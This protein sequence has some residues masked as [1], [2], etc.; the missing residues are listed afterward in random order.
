MSD[1]C[2]IAVL[3]SGPAALAVGAAC[4]RRGA[5][6]TLVAPDPFE[7]WRPNYCLWRDELPDSLAS[8]IECAWPEVAVA[9]RY[10]EQTLKRGY[11]KIDNE[12]LRH[13]FWKHLDAGDTRV[14]AEPAVRLEPRDPGTWVH[15]ARDSVVRARV[16]IDASGA[17]SPFVRRVHTRAPA[18]QVAYGLLLDAPG[19][20]FPVH[21]ATLMDF[22]PAAANLGE[23]PSFVY[24]LPLS[25]D[26]VFLEET[27]LARR[28]SVS[29]A[30]LQ[31][32]L[33]ARLE[34]LGLQG[35]EHLGEE[36]CSIPMGLGLPIHGQSLVPFGAAAAM[37]HPASGY[38]IAHVLR[39][40]EPVAAALTEPLLAG[41]AELAVAAANA[42]LWPRSDRTAWE[43]YG[44]GLETLISMDT[45]E[46]GRFFDAFFRLPLE[47]WA[48]F[49]KGVLSPR[50]L[51][52][53]M[54]RLFRSLPASVRWHLVRTGVSRGAAPLARTVLQPGTT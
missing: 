35:C 30:L 39:K 16:V 12:A 26:R 3:G 7:P 19:H 24:V 13:F 28:P 5:S 25:P 2:D 31:K 29:M 54:T 36:H 51:G 27:S 53:V 32:R 17:T 11:V 38:S 18:F 4:A 14:I 40:A 41:D 50:E 44:F 10:G 47:D 42:A 46:I 6:V 34:S 1:S 43:L 22:R 37:V 45:Q 48:G 49:L 9:S 23:P 20:G 52:A 8:L 21:R 15:T 33:D